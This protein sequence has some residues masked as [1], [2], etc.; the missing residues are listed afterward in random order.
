VRIG[1]DATCWSNQRGYGRYARG[2]LN[3]LLS[4]SSD[5][6][7]YLFFVD[8]QT[9]SNWTF[10]V[11]AEVVTVVTSEAPTIAA[12]SDSRRSMKDLWAMTSAVSGQ[13]LDAFFFPSVYTYFPIIGQANI[14]LGIHDVIPELFPRLVFPKRK[15]RTLWQSKG[16]LA[17]RQADYILTV[18][19]YAKAGIVRQ[20][21]WDPG[22]VWVVGEAPDPVFQPISDVKLIKKSLEQHDLKPDVRYVICLGGLNPHKNLGTLFEVLSKL[23]QEK[24]FNDLQLVLVGPAEDDNFTPGV[25]QARLS[26]DNFGIR[27]AV[28]FTGFIPDNDVVCMLNAAQALVMPSLE[29]GFGLGAVEAAACGTPVVATRNSPLPQ[30]LDGGGL[31]VDPKRPEELYDALVQILSDESR[32]EK[33]GKTALAKAQELSWDRSAEQ[34]RELL[35]NIDGTLE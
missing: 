30:I 16:W 25:S 15:Q 21:N 1:I 23:R 4:D 27:D 12:A 33:M 2:L 13:D 6:N 19:E 31:F 29:E 9:Q 5:H 22:R 35:A 10:P 28:H 14:I 20:F 26:V 3:A 34:F 32:H 7:Q 24:E 8:D 11:R 18:S 17:R